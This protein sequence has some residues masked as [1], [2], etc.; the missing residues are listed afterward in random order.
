MRLSERKSKTI[1]GSL[2]CVICESPATGYNFGVIACESCKAFFRRNALKN[3]VSYPSNQRYF[4]CLN[5]E[6]ESVFSC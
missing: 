2:T 4:Y 5:E 6:L 3:P 1:H